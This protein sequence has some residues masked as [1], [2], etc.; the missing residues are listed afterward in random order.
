[1]DRFNTSPKKLHY[2]TI[3]SF[4]FGIAFCLPHGIVTGEVAPALGLIPL[5][6]GA[7]LALYRSSPFQSRNKKNAAGVEYQILLAEEEE[8]DDQNNK[9]SLTWQR[10]FVALLDFG[11]F[12]GLIVTVVFSIL[13]NND[14]RCRYT[15]G[16]NTHAGVRH[17]YSYAR[18]KSMQ[19]MLA[20]WATMVM[21]V[22]A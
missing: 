13:S 11:C 14:V 4:L 7:L 2:I 18:C 22:N 6:I 12:G 10:L 8:E 9:N 20:A 17:S 1:M 15:Y 19:P 16:S 5:G 3:V 21:L